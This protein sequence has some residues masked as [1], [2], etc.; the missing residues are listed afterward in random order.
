M[1]APPPTF[2]PLSRGIS[3][4]Y[5]IGMDTSRVLRTSVAIAALSAA[6]YGG[7]VAYEGWEGT[8]RPPVKGDVPTVGFGSTRHADGRQVRAG[9]TIAPPE[10]V[11]L[12]LSH[13]AKDESRLKACFGPETRIAPREWDAFVSLAYNVGTSAVCASSIPG[14]L[15]A[16]DYA[17]AC[18]T[19]LDFDQFCTRP[20]IKD[21]AGKLVCPQGAK[22]RLP[23]LTRRRAAEY[24][25]CMGSEK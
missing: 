2:V 25:A 19:I 3:R 13:I 4:P 24:R 5:I 7:I 23:G 17:A 1:I 21:A 9:E 8:A 22:K 16:G 12:A 18:R 11:R 14:K 15:E 20:K 6:G 10:A